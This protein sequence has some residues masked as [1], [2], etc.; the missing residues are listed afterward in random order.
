MLKSEYYHEC[1]K[2]NMFKHLTNS[3]FQVNKTKQNIVGFSLSLDPFMPP[4]QLLLI[5]PISN[6]YS[7]F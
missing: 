6:H 5:A 3:G 7:D 4:I 1:N 2:L